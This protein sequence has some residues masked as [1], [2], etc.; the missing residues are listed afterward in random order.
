MEERS[1]LDEPLGRLLGAV[2]AQERREQRATV[3]GGGEA[4]AVGQRPELAVQLQQLRRERRGWRA[5]RGGALP[6]GG[7]PHGG[8]EGRRRGDVELGQE[9]QQRRQLRPRRAAARRDEL[10]GGK[11]GAARR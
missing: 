2:A 1:V 10:C 6:E 9:L 11:V 8:R 7:E 5:L 4:A 3:E